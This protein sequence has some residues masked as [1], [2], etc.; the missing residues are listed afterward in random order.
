MFEFG[1]WLSNRLEFKIEHADL[2]PEID[3]TVSGRKILHTAPHRR[4]GQ[5]WLPSELVPM[6]QERDAGAALVG[7]LRT[8]NAPPSDQPSSSSSSIVIRRQTLLVN[9]LSRKLIHTNRLFVVSCLDL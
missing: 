3:K 1:R 8:R 5:K 6:Q 7:L 4:L 2:M 9:F